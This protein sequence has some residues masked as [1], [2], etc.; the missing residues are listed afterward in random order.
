MLYA[1]VGYS[2]V[3]YDVIPEQVQ[4]ALKDIED[5]LHTLKN[6]KLLRGNISA[7][8]Q[9]KLISGWLSVYIEELSGATALSPQ[10]YAESPPPTHSQGCVVFGHYSVPH[11]VMVEGGEH[12]SGQKLFLLQKSTLHMLVFKLI[13]DSKKL[14]EYL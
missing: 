9:L 8:D 12:H 1:S 6:E 11:K 3:I 7:E 2:V 4:T 14:Y 13:H 10:G 5:Q